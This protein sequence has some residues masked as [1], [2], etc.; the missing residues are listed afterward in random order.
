MTITQAL[1][2]Q[3]VW[4]LAAGIMPWTFACAAPVADGGNSEIGEATEELVFEQPASDGLIDK[5]ATEYFEVGFS[6]P[7]T[8]GVATFLADGRFFCV[9]SQV[10]NSYNVRNAARV[11]TFEGQWFGRGVGRAICIRADSFERGPGNWGAI[12]S[13]EQSAFM[14]TDRN[15]DVFSPRE[16]VRNDRGLLNF[17]CTSLFNGDAF[18][19]INGIA[20]EMQAIDNGLGNFGESVRITQVGTPASSSLLRVRTHSGL[21]IGASHSLF[22]GDP[23]NRRLVKLRGFNEVG[24]E[25]TGNITTPGQF[26][27]NVMATGGFNEVVMTRSD[28]SFCG[29]TLL[30][31]NLEGRTRIQITERFM[32]VGQPSVWV[33]SATAPDGSAWAQARCMAYDQR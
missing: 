8:G 27:F 29:F 2:L 30:S 9:L 33:L 19:F 17:A 28:L 7:E 14:N 10:Q 4:A 16:C 5:A 25:T 20:G 15:P 6:A 32:G 24:R 3:A 22:V 11:F 12:M 18:S 26:T 13:G 31:G 21:L 23:A 1:R